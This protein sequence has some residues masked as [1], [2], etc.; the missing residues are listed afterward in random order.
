MKRIGS[1]GVVFLLVA[2]L[3]L[4]GCAPLL[5]GSGLVA[6]YLATKDSVSGNIETSFERLWN[7][8]LYVLKERGEIVDYKRA[9]GWIKAR[10]KGN[11]VTVNIK[12][13]TEHSYKLHV[14]ARKAVAIANLELAQEVFTKIIRNLDSGEKVIK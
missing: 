12:E 10:Y 9:L 5:I 3:F 8:S 1:F 4:S 11:A 14:R 7:K 13:L 2:S 6:G